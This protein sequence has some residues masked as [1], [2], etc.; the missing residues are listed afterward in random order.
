MAWHGMGH[1][2]TDEDGRLF[3]EAGIEMGGVL[4]GFWGSCPTRTDF[5]VFLW[6]S[7]LEG[8]AE[9]CFFQWQALEGVM[10]RLIDLDS[11]AGRG[12]CQIVCFPWESR[13]ESGHGRT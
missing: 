12:L 9:A 7:G 3:G 1:V 6:R 4:F 11:H 2:M 5:S 13:L 10:R 8:D